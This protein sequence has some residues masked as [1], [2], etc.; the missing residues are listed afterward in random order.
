MS[1]PPPRNRRSDSIRNRELLLTAAREVFAA[2]G[3]GATLDEIAQ[4]AGL[5][6]G[7]AYRHFPNKQAVAAEVLREATERI[8]V[9]AR[10]ALDVGDPWEALVRFFDRTATR[11][12]ADRGLYE[13]LTG[14]GDDEAQARIWP[15]IIAAVTELLDR[16]HRAGVVRPDVA[17][18]D[19][20]VIFAMMGAV[21]DLSREI[22]P[23]LW[24]RYLTLLLDGLRADGRP[25]LPVP[26]PPVGALDTV[27]RAGKRRPGSTVDKR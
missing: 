22:E 20:A 18:Q 10:E 2:R 8:A 27:L 19:V 24:R 13:T 6:T 5:G 16:A 11:Q 14:Q 3:F 21:F 1:A 12:A 9:D 15:Q 23:N 26:P 25:A 17:P 7:T 4:H